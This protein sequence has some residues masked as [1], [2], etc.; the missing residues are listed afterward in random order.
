MGKNIES[1]ISKILSKNKDSVFIL[2]QLSRET[3]TRNFVVID[4]REASRTEQDLFYINTYEIGRL[5]NFLDIDG[6][7]KIDIEFTDGRELVLEYYEPVK[8]QA[9]YEKLLYW[10]KKRNPDDE[11]DYEDDTEDSDSDSDSDYDYDDGGDDGDETPQPIDVFFEF[12]VSGNGVSAQYP[13]E[14]GEFLFYSTSTPPIQ[15]FDQ[16]EIMIYEDVI[17]VEYVPGNLIYAN[18]FYKLHEDYEHPNQNYYEIETITLHATMEDALSERYEYP[19]FSMK[20]IPVAVNGYPTNVG[21]F[22][23][24]DSYIY[25][26]P[27]SYSSGGGKRGGSSGTSSSS[28]N[29]G[30]TSGNSS[31]G[32]SGSGSSGSSSSGGNPTNQQLIRTY[33]WGTRW[34]PNKTMMNIEVGRIVNP[35]NNLVVGLSY[36]QDFYGGSSGSKELVLPSE[37]SYVW[38]VIKCICVE[39]VEGSETSLELDDVEHIELFVTQNECEEYV[40]QQPVSNEIHYHIRR[41]PVVPSH[42]LFIQLYPYQLLG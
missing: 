20:T 5:E 32:S 21:N 38:G 10:F 28:V 35:E 16:S 37:Y 23:A 25:P 6:F 19:S 27:K 9:D 24:D 7:Y 1:V 41:F 18:I 31:S 26:T 36:M 12:T 15:Y 34:N 30:S 2:N 13:L 22:A 40:S 14:S 3:D 39:T 17:T 4:N 8:M 11:Y 33:H 29:S 42:N